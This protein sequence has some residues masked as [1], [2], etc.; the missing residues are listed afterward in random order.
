MEGTS[1]EIHQSIEEADFDRGEH[2]RVLIKT[3]GILVKELKASRN[4]I[5]KM[6]TFLR[7]GILTPETYHNYIVETFDISML[8]VYMSHLEELRQVPLRLPLYE[9]FQA[10]LNMVSTANMRLR[11]LVESMAKEFG[12][13]IT[14]PLPGSWDMDPELCTLVLALMPFKGA[15]KDGFRATSPGYFP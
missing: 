9:D 14:P 4:A 8:A 11:A 1:C 13:Q 12:L 15:I 6:D 5:L 3:T 7:N 10:A 2:K